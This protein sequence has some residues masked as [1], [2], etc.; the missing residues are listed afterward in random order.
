MRKTMLATILLILIALA[1]SGLRAGTLRQNML[2]AD[3]HWVMHLDMEQFT[4]TR[5]FQLVQT[6]DRL[7]L[8][9]PFE[10]VQEELMLD[11]YTDLFG[12]TLF[13]TNGR[14]SESVVC[15]QGN[16]DRKALLD[17]LGE[18]KEYQELAHGQHTIYKWDSKQCAT[19][20]G[21]NLIYFG[22]SETAIRQALDVL[23]G[24]APSIAETEHLAWLNQAPANAFAVAAVENMT[25]M[26]KAHEAATILKQTRMAAFLAQEQ[27]ENLTL[28]VR[29]ETDTPEAAVQIEQ[30]ARG[31][32]AMA[33]LNLAKEADAAAVLRALQIV[34]EDRVVNMQ[35]TYPSAEI[36]DLLFNK[37]LGMDIDI[38]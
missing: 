25:E 34:T 38:D 18:H 30:I 9:A 13:G 14:H 3:T 22:Q 23:D 2:P 11:P 29:L 6:D 32:L 4:G 16:F 19:F 35:W 31:L 28:R 10:E 15:L 8:R 5:L 36:Y 1:G 33:Q 27:D 24:F 12:L 17:R 37:K 21:S 20:A 7:G 26:V